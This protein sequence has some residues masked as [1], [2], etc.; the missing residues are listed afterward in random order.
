MSPRAAL[1]NAPRRTHIRRPPCENLTQNR[2]EAEHVGPF[3]DRF[4]VAL[5]LFWRHIGWCPQYAARLG[6]VATPGGAAAHDE[7]AG[8]AIRCAGSSSATRPS[9]STL[10]RPQSITCTSP[11]LPTITLAG[12]KSRWITRRAWA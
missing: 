9:G 6:F 4:R 12:F 7:T 2:P 8:S 11:K 1:P 10:A 5:C 3:V